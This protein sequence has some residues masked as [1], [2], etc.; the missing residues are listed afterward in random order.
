MPYLAVQKLLD[1]AMLKGMLH[2][3]TADFLSDLPDTTVDTL[4]ELAT[5][6]VSPLTQVILIPG[7]G[8]ISR[9]AEDATAFG[10]RQTR[11]NIHS[12]SVWADPL[13]TDR[14]IAYIRHV[15][16]AMKPWTTGRAYLNFLG[17]EGQQRIATAFGP[18][19]YP[20]LQTLKA[21]YDPT[22]LLCNNQNIQPAVALPG[23]ALRSADVISAS[24]GLTSRPNG[25]TAL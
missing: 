2:Y 24:S 17:D 4:L 9:V 6:P 25:S 21:R 7:G 10:N 12:L 13:D 14:N 19:N 22:N 15:T 8:A 23:G 20:R 18:D 3:W 1:P 11:W 5:Q 16:T